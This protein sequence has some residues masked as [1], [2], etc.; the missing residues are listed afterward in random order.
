VK[1]LLIGL[2][3]MGCVG[4]VIGLSSGLFY[5]LAYGVRYGLIYGLIIGLIAITAVLLAGVL[6][7]GWS[8]DILDAQQIF[9]PNEGIRRSLLNAV[10]AAVLFGLA[11]SLI[12]G[13]VCAFA[14]GVVGELSSW[15]VLSIGFA[16]V[17]GVLFALQ[18]L[19]IHGGI[20]WAEHYFLRWHFQRAGY[21][22]WNC[23][24]FFDYTSER[25]L[26]R[27]VGGGY[28]FA[29]RLLLEHFASLKVS[30]NDAP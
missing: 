29:H 19:T 24:D 20:A 13:L 6:N 17:F 12:S 23:I 5:G 11:G 15:L 30:G 9:R 10:I 1:G 22:P 2:I 4:L 7:S 28:M 21:M 14:F 16:I 26:L 8:S 18:F 27:K 3:V 25:I